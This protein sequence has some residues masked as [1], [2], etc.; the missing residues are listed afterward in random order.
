MK[1]LLT[2]RLGGLAALVLCLALT[3]RASADLV[4]NGG[5]ET[6]TFAGWTQF[7]NTGFTEVSTRVVHSGNFAGEFGPVGS[8]GGIFQNLTTV[9]GQ[10]YVISF[11]LQNDGDVPNEFQF[12]WGGTLIQDRV[13][14]GAQPYTEVTFTLT[15]TSTTTELRFGFRQD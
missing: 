15:A 5:F 3:G 4:T 11:W 12:S 1:Q 6:G 10:S 9:A 2:V 13:N 8:I 14:F 7:G